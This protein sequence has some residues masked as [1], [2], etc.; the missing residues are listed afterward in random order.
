[1]KSLAENRNVHSFGDFFQIRVAAQ[2]L[3]GFREHGNTGGSGSFVGAGNVKIG[4]CVVNDASGGAGLFHFGN[5][6]QPF[7]LQGFLEGKG[8]QVARGCPD[9]LF[10]LFLWQP[11]FVLLCPALC[12]T[13]KGLQNGGFRHV[14]HRLRPG[15]RQ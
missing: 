4:E 6:R 14:I 10:E 15:L 7:G 1:M 9:Q 12:G 11:P 2:K 3:C 8:R 13:G 5:D